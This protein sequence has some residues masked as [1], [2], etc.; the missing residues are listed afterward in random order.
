MAFLYDSRKVSFGGLASEIVIPPIKDPQAGGKKAT[1]IPAQQLART[2]FMV[3]FRV[4][5]FAFT[6]CTTRILYGDQKPENPEC[7]KEIQLLSAVLSRARVREAR[8]GAEHDHVG[9][10]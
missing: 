10:L 7:V 8:V 1:C 5:W 4:G 6:L 3:G 2:P 9:R